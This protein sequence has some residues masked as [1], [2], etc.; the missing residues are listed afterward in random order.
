[1]LIKID[2]RDDWQGASQY[3]IQQHECMTLHLID[4][5]FGLPYYTL[6]VAVDVT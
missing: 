5:R 6:L 1:M 3:W 2:V 4:R